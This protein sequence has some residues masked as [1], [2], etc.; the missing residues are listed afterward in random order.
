MIGSEAMA[1]SGSAAEA[2]FKDGL[3]RMKRNDFVG[4]CAA[5]EHS[6]RLD[7]QYGTEL[8]LAVC[9]VRIHRLY[10]AWKLY[11]EVAA[12][13][14][15]TD[16][17]ARAARGADE[18]WPYI[19]KLHLRSDTTAVAIHVTIDATDVTS[20]MNTDIPVEPGRHAIVAS[21]PGASEFRQEVDLAAGEKHE[22]Q[23]WFVP[24]PPARSPERAPPGPAPAPPAP[25]PISSSRASWGWIAIGS[26]SALVLGGLGAG[27]DAM[28]LKDDGQIGRASVWADASTFAIAIGAA[29]IGG[30]VYLWRSS[31]GDP[32]QV[33]AA[34]AP[35]SASLVLSGGF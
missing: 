2:T 6:Q 14:R 32:V 17:A 19:P 13:D 18:I 30:G 16:R 27:W 22:V 34:A 10:D 11:C 8:N 9:Y 33:Q 31:R 28:R 23:I 1:Q 35:A 5:L 26:G 20:R 3:L 25:A 4:A 15:D 12:G 21:L 24:A 29:A 7:P